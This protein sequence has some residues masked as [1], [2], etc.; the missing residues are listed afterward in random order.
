[1]PY[2][3][4][5]DRSNSSILKSGQLRRKSAVLHDVVAAVLAWYLAFSLRFNFQIPSEFYHSILMNGRWVIPI[6][7]LMFFQFGL[8]RGI[9]RFASLPDLKRIIYAAVS[10]SF[11]IIA[12]K[13]MV[14]SKEVIPRS[15]HVLDPMLLIMIMGGSR[16]IYRAWKDHHLYALNSSMGKPV[17]ILGAGEV[18]VNLLNDLARS[19]EWR[20]VGLLDNQTNLHFRELK[21]VRVLGAIDDLPL[22]AQDSDVEHVIVAFSQEQH[23][24][25][26]H[27]IE[28]ANSL[29]LKILTVPSLDDLMSGKL[30]ISQIRKVE[31]EDL[32]G[33]DPVQLA[34]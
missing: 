19:Q 33:R 6:Q 2:L 22:Y 20:V 8:Y 11:L 27:S 16:F 5:K 15:V 23:A 28:L 29:G 34:D 18:A 9:W 17:L 26:K 7:L 3:N 4:K 32:L 30:S 31:V 12:V 25:K 24:L 21:G 10:A 1:M 14:I 13:M